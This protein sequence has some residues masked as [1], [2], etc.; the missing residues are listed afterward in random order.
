[1]NGTPMDPQRSPSEGGLRQSC[2]NIPGVLSYLKAATPG[3]IAALVRRLNIAAPCRPR[4][5]WPESSQTRGLGPFC[6]VNPIRQGAMSNIPKIP[7]TVKMPATERELIR[8]ATETESLSPHAWMR[9]TL[10]MQARQA[11]RAESRE[12]KDN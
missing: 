1:M 12:P 3:H 2:A 4:P 7:V 11:V 5:E 8:Q 6:A 10:A 9:R